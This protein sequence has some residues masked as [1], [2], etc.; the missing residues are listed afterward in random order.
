MK[1]LPKLSLLTIMLVTLTALMTILFS[2]NT[3]KS[4]VYDLNTQLVEKD[5]TSVHQFIKEEYN[6]LQQHGLQNVK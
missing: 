6:A 4:I 3:I 1:L 2:I 5:L